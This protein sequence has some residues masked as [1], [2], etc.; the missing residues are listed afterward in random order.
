[1]GVTSNNDSF[2]SFAKEARLRAGLGLREAARAIGISAAYLSR[3][4]NGKEYPSGELMGHMSRLYKIPLEDLTSR[5]T[6]P[7]AS[8]AAHGL[9]M[10]SS[11]ELRALYRLAAQLEASELAELIRR[12]LRDKGIADKEIEK[13]LAVLK[14]ELP[15]ISKNSRDG[16]FAA[17]VKPRFL[18][19]RKIAQMAYELL[20]RNGLTEESYRPPTHIEQIVDREKGIL[21]AIRELGSDRH[22]NPLVLGLTGWDE[23]GNRQIVISSLLADSRRESDAHRF[24]FTLAH[25]LFHA[26]EHLP[27]IASGNVAPMARAQQGAVFIDREPGKFRSAAERAVNTWARK[28]AGPRGLLTNEDWREWQS[29]TFASAILMPEWAVR[30]EFQSR[31]EI[32]HLSVC[33]GSNLREE[34]LEI[35]GS[36]TLGEDFVS[37]SLAET[38]AVSRQAMAIRL[39][40]L[41]MIRE[42]AG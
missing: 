29:N 35:A 7:R 27:R 10:Q 22:G 41:G 13:Q 2:G 18:S 42:V 23:E 6:K 28:D 20:H 17:E 30:R 14:N 26:L 11:P 12:F 15:R 24:S 21:Y 8:A 9:A 32:E 33:R 4:E 3:V 25:E 39:I 34:A 19:K 16:L 38:F 5:A 1:M 36:V 31:Y 37:D 40:E